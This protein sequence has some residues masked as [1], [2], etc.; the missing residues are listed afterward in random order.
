MATDQHFCLRWN[1]HQSTLISVFDTL[2]ESGTLVDCTLAADGQQ[3]K[4]HKVVLSACSPYL[5]SLLSQHYDKHPIIILRDVKFPEL[6]AML[7]YMYRGEVNITQEQLG[8]FLKA[9][10]SLQIKG[11]TDSGGGA[12]G[13]VGELRD[14][15]PKLRKQIP[16]PAAITP[17]SRPHSGIVMEPRKSVPHIPSHVLDIPP[18]SPL[19]AREGSV[20]PVV[21]KRRKPNQPIHNDDAKLV[22]MPTALHS[23]SMHNSPSEPPSS[24]PNTPVTGDAATPAA[25]NNPNSTT[26][27]TSD[28]GKNVPSESAKSDGAAVVKV[29]QM[30]PLLQPKTEYSEDINDN[31]NENSVED[32]TIEEDDDEEGIDMSKPG[33]SQAANTQGYGAWM[34]GDS[35]SEETGGN[36]AGNQHNSQGFA[37]WHVAPDGPVDETMIAAHQDS[38]ESPAV[39]PLAIPGKYCCLLCNK[40]YLWKQSLTRHIREDRCDKGPQHLCPICGMNFKHTSRL[41]RHVPFCT[42]TK[43][44]FITQN[45]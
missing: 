36:A 13:G 19:K 43:F 1:N 9:A 4:A 39:D 38:Q 26:N 44:E 31:D 17:Q 20:S 3:L 11:L 5:E 6:K 18:S 42:Q 35:S 33:P 30:E 37:Q 28:S 23:E 45:S 15:L 27:K 2:L 22:Q 14:G 41:V 25:G 29:E 8:T 40:T 24:T 16:V 34:E 21:R 12:G 32:V 7:D 10:E